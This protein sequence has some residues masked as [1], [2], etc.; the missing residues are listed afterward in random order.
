MANTNVA[1][2]GILVLAPAL[3]YCLP[4]CRLELKVTREAPASLGGALQVTWIRPVMMADPGNMG[5]LIPTAAS[6]ALR[7]YKGLRR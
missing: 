4:R 3:A 2:G 6:S 5:L 7:R 1:K